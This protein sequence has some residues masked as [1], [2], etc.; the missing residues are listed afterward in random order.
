ME[1]LLEVGLITWEIEKGLPQDL[2]ER[3]EELKRTW[4]R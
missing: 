3:L 4:K 2:R 1:D